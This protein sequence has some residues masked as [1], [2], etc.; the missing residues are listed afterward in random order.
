MGG[1]EKNVEGKGWEEEEMKI[2]TEEARKNN[3][4]DDS[5]KL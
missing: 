5:W 4:D 3:G 1:R 2:K